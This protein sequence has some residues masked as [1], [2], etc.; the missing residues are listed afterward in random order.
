MF[1]LVETTICPSFIHHIFLYASEIRCT[2]DNIQPW[3]NLPLLLYRIF[4]P[5]LSYVTNS[6]H[7]EKKMCR[8]EHLH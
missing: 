4:Q 5:R 1:H 3:K 2:L 6:N 7:V 8:I